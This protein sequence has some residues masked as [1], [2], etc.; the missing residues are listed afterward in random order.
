MNLGF[1]LAFDPWDVT[2]FQ[3]GIYHRSHNTRHLWTVGESVRRFEENRNRSKK[4]DTRQGEV[5]W[6]RVL[7]DQGMGGCQGPV[8][9]MLSVSCNL[10]S[11]G[12]AGW[13]TL[14]M[15]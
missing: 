7:W 3:V 8:L 10:R 1:G 11:E 2:Q 14:L 15:T 12:R 6:L 5:K 9:W 13:W 4:Q